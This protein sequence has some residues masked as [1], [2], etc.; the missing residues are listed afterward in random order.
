MKKKI[1]ISIWADPS[2][3]I[4]LLFLI[5]HFLKKKVEIILICQF[6][7]K[8][9]DFY[10]FVKRSKNLK[11]LEINKK[12]KIGYLYFFLNKLILLIRHKP[13]T[14]ISINFI[15]LFFSYLII[16]KKLNWV[17]YNFDFNITSEF[18]LNNYLEKKIISKVNFVLLPSKSRVQIYK[19]SFLRKKNIFSINN[20]FS[21]NFKIKKYKLNK[22]N[23]K[24]KRKNYFLRLGSFYKY[25]FL[26]E[27]AL[28]TK[29]W[30][31][32][33]YLVMAGKS[34]DG[35][36]NEI[37]DL[38]KKYNLSQLILIKNISYK[39]WFILL[40]NAIAGFALYKSINTSH[41]LMGGTS[42]KLNNYIFAGIPSFI[43][44]NKDFMEFN[45]K[46]NTSILVNNSIKDISKKVNTLINNK[47]FYNFKINKNKTAFNNEFNF[48][49]QISKIEKFII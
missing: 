15:S 5:N 39:T 42:Q 11:V 16:N 2:N 32:N 35:Y 10:Y 29:Y 26:K 12:G 21:K 23:N 6:I 30:K 17:Y 44:K 3:Y 25:H 49:K 34:Y 45:K 40:K 22:I 9:N 19:K 28:S 18:N 7:E 47:S 48:E 27:L 8:K 20:C 33:I 14:L 31:K 36:F 46:Y 37:N 43:S 24:L 4:N 41:Q 1:I 13:K 38:K